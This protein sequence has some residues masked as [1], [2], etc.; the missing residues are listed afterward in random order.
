[1]EDNRESHEYLTIAD[2]DGNVLTSEEIR[3]RVEYNKAHKN[4]VVDRPIETIRYYQDDNNAIK[5]DYTKEV[6]YVLDQEQ[7][8]WEYSEGYTNMIKDNAE[9][10]PRLYNFYEGFGYKS[11]E[12]TPRQL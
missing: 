11:V 3:R 10:L 5:Y 4:D 8:L 7:G 12:D 9:A 2:I 1:M 6:A